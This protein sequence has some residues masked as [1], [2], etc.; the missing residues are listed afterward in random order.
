M[1]QA[2]QKKCRREIAEIRVKL[3]EEWVQK[4][5]QLQQQEEA[6]HL[7][8]QQRQREFEEHSYRNRQQVFA[9]IDTI[10]AREREVRRALDV[11]KKRLATAEDR[12]KEMR[13]ELQHRINTI[14]KD[15]HISSRSEAD[16]RRQLREEREKFQIQLRETASW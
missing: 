2:E 5:H 10:R 15:K 3:N 4:M 9:E 16:L 12:L 13:N 14:D 1:R 7:R 6:M 11:D 8:N